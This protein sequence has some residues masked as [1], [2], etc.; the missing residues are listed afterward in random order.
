M[1]SP[2]SLPGKAWKATTD[3]TAT[4]MSAILE[5][6]IAS[7]LSSDTTSDVIAHLITEVETAIIAADKAAEAERDKA[8][9]PLASPDPVKARAAMED[10]TFTRDRLRT[11]LPR[12]QQRFSE[13]KARIEEVDHE[14]KCVNS[15][16]PFDAKEANGDGRWLLETELAARDIEALR[17]HRQVAASTPMMAKK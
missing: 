1:K 12:L 9:D 15:E 17:M 13:V 16:K 3:K 11:V 14:A 5:Q 4:A 6:Q 10:A 7:A 8:L 2:G